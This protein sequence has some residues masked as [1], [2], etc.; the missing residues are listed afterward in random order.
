[1]PGAVSL[2]AMNLVADGALKP[3]GE[4]KAMFDDA[5]VDLDKP[6]ITTCGSGATAATLMLALKLAGAKDVAVYDGSWA[7]WAARP[8]AQIVTD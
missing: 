7:E 4:L 5:G 3:I 8:D 1:M 2:P 6:I